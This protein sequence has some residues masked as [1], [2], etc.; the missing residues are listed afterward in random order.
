MNHIETQRRHYLLSTEQEA[1]RRAN[2]ST[3]FPPA[4]K[5]LDVPQLV[6]NRNQKGL[7]VACNR[8]RVLRGR[9]QA[10]CQ[11]T[12][13]IHQ[14]LHLHLRPALPNEVPQHLSESGSNQPH[15]P[16]SSPPPPPPGRPLPNHHQHPC[17][18]DITAGVGARPS[19]ARTKSTAASLRSPPPAHCPAR[20]AA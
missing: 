2:V 7:Q 16:E 5:Q 4:S 20:S 10:G 18:S 9:A 12:C 13:T 19:W 6:A 17:M 1:G 8:L 11:P 3:E 15:P 14:E